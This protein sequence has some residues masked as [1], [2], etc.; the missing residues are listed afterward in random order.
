MLGKENGVITQLVRHNTPFAF[1]VHCL[2]HRLALAASD[3]ADLVGYLQS[4]FKPTL[5]QLFYFFD[6]SPVRS[7]HLEEIE[8][9]LGEDLLKMH[10][11]CLFASAMF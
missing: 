11:V 4:K 2:A 3:A 5:I 9:C 1:N 8:G 10:K 6:N 7:A